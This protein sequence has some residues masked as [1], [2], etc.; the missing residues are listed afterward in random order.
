MDASITLDGSCR[1]E[2]LGVIR[3]E[4]P[5]AAAFLQGQLTNDV[6]NLPESRARLAGFCSAKGR[7]QATFIVWRSGATTFYLVCSTSLLAATMKRLSMFVMRAKCKL[8]DASAEIELHGQVGRSATTTLADAAVWDKRELAAGSVVRLP[9]VDG[10]PRA[11]VALPA[12][13]GDGFE[14]HP[15]LSVDAWR[16]LD[17]RSGI[18]TIEAATVDLFVPQMLNFELVGGVDFQK[19]CYPGQEVVARSQY[20]GT[21]KRRTFLF[22]CDALPSPGEDVFASGNDAGEPVGIVVN[23]ARRPDSTGASALIEVRLGALD[24]SSLHLASPGGSDLRRV[25]L[26]YPVV[27]EADAAP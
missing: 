2:D 12:G 13:S 10:L 20:R 25:A 17:V 21:T 6:L 7:L 23:A 4:G 26:P 11:L 22:D 19:G 14:G 15:A 18:C 24:A 5:D 3:A 8:V 1:I 9:D 27:L 16:W